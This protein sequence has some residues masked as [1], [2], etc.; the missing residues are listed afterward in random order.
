MIIRATERFL[1]ATRWLLLPFLAGLVIGLAIL[2]LRF[3]KELWEL[4]KVLW[5]GTNK[6][7][8][9]GLL[10]LV[11]VVLIAGL[12]VIVMLSSYENF[13]ARVNA[14]D[15]PRWPAWMARMD[16]A[17]L[18]HKLIATMATIA[19]MEVLKE[20]AS[21]DDLSD[22]YLAWAIGIQLALVVTAVLL[23]FSDR[24]AGNGHQPPPPRP[25]PPR[26]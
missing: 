24:L 26:A 9:T 21:I 1:F 15:H 14:E 10:S 23:T 11:E 25:P 17:Q 19:S 4:M 8:L 20:I 2:L 5:S 6:E 12:I 7:V 13:L 3:V 22:R 16:F 18:K